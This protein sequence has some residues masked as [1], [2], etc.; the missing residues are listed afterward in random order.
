[1][2]S[3]AQQGWRVTQQLHGRAG[4]G[5]WQSNPRAHTASDTSLQRGPQGKHCTV[6]RLAFALP[7][8]CH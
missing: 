5:V 6:G 2:R 4:T 3:S 7:I 8:T 1:M